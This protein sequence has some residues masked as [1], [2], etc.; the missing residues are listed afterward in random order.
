MKLQNNKVIILTDNNYKSIVEHAEL[1]VFILA[2]ASQSEP[3]SKVALSPLDSLAY[4]Y[5]DRVCIATL[6]VDR[7]LQLIDAL[8]I[9]NVP[10]VTL[11]KYGKLLSTHRNITQT[12]ELRKLIEVL[13]KIS[14]D[15]TDETLQSIEQHQKPTEEKIDKL[16]AA[17]EDRMIDTDVSTEDPESS[18]SQQT[19]RTNKTETSTEKPWLVIGIILLAL[20]LFSHLAGN[21]AMSDYLAISDQ[22]RDLYYSDQINTVE[23]R[24]CRQPMNQYDLILM[25]APV[26]STILPFFGV[27]CIVL[28]LLRRAKR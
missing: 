23:W 14:P 3:A 28:V 1:P 15:E 22:C 24:E 8:A 7:N 12:L 6:D 18:K 27:F 9:G 25:F 13:I 5:G 16:E 20:A 17:L 4:E 2:Y 19:Q 11:I 26:G 10:S 21:S